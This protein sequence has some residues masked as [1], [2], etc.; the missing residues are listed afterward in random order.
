[1]QYTRLIELLL[2][3]A[4]FLRNLSPVEGQFQASLTQVANYYCFLSLEFALLLTQLMPKTTP[5]SAIIAEGV[6]QVGSFCIFSFI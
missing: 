2:H 6:F 5:W 1:L 3:L 4:A